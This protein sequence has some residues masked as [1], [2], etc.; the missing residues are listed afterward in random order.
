MIRLAYIIFSLI[1]LIIGILFAVLNA[2]PVILH[3]YFG[4]KHIPLSL[5][6]ISAIIIGAILGIIA[7]AGIIIKLKRDNSKLKKL[8]ELSEKELTNLRTMPIKD[9]H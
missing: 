6:L 7:S 2:E 5:V 1:L 8:T 9:E 4:D 3:Y